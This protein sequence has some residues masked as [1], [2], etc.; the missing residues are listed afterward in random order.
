MSWINQNDTRAEATVC[1]IVYRHSGGSVPQS[2]VLGTFGRGN[3]HV[4]HHFGLRRMRN[5]SFCTSPGE[6]SIAFV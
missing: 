6:Y 3:T 2:K 5:E 4:F 1:L